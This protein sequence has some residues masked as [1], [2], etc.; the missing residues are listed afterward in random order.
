MREIL[1][2]AKPIEKIN[3]TR[4][5]DFYEPIKRTSEEILVLPTWEEVC[6]QKRTHEEGCVNPIGTQFK[7]KDGYKI[8]MLVYKNYDSEYVIN[9]TG[10]DFTVYY[11]ELTKENYTLACRKCK[12]LFL[13]G[14][15]N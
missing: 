6:K 8:S 7:S 2:R 10:E 11:A 14:E 15:D 3:K 9:V 13:G 12:E 1:F 4:E 5:K